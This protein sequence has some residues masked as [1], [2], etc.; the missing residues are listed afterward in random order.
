MNYKEDS[1][2][3][4]FYIFIILYNIR[5]NAMDMDGDVNCVF[6]EIHRDS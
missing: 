1:T 6:I 4:G 3:C 5:L 2:Y